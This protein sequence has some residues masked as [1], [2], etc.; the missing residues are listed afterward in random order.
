MTNYKTVYPE[1]ALKIE[2]KWSK[3]QLISEFNDV[4]VKKPELGYFYKFVG[5]YSDSFHLVYI[6]QSYSRFVYERIKDRDHIIKQG[7]FNINHP[8]IKLYVSV[9]IINQSKIPGRKLINDVEKLL[10]YSHKN[11]DHKYMINK[12]AT[13]N[14]HVKANYQIINSAFLDDGMLKE[15]YYGLFFK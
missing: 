7:N 4:S 5:K 13:I 14:H 3:P 8:H 12:K 10:I 2:I 6:G 15:I 1:E 11:D 9:G